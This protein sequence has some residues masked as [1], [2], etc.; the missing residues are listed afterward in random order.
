MLHCCNNCV[1]CDV[2]CISILWFTFRNYCVVLLNFVYQKDQIMKNKLNNNFNTDMNNTRLT[3]IE[4]KLDDLM[5]VVTKLIEKQSNSS[6][7]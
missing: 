1:L 5:K 2:I 7:V 6:P 4:N 3:R